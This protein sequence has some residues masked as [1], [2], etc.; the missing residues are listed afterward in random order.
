MPFPEKINKGFPED[1]LLGTATSAFQVEGAGDTEW[2]NFIGDDG[3]LLDISI[4]H[5]K[6]VEE[7]LEYI[8]YL[9]NSYRFSMDWSK[10]Q[11]NP[12]DPL[13]KDAVDHYRI[14]FNTLKN[15]KKK[16]MLV[17]NH[18]SNPGW[19]YR[20]GGWTNKE[21]P[22]LFFDYVKKVINIFYDHIDILNTFNEPNA[23]VNMA[24]FFRAFPPKKFNLFLRNTALS[25]MQKSHSLVY[26]FIKERYP[27]I[28]VG[29]SHAHMIVEPLG[30][31]TP[32]KLFIKKFFDFIEHEHLHEFFIKNGSEVDYIGFSYYGRILLERFPLLAYNKYGRKRLDELGIR[33]D[34]MWELFPEGIYKMLHFFYNKY[35]KPLIITENGTCTTD[36]ELR[37]TSLQEHLSFVQKACDDNVPVLGYFH[38]STFD[39]YELAHGPSRRFGLTAIGY[40][41]PGLERKIKGS[42]HYYHKVVESKS[43]PER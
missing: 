13:E 18:F 14:I 3:T 35:K 19:F 5:Y 23:Y 16:I 37:K 21:A 29:I 11:K 4:D 42:G 24:Y 39:N 34:D 27:G 9:G 7:D 43:I 41:S 31:L 2:K 20:T 28:P 10:L 6:N 26:H 40:S 8:C 33:H 15:K 30:H 38:W 1:F 12:Y 22:L 32:D 36:D 25:N 17:L